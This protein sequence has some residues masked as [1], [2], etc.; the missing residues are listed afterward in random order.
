MATKAEWFRYHAERSGPKKPKQ[1]KKSRPEPKPHNL[2]KKDKKALYAFE[3]HAPGTRPS[4]KSSRKA[5]NRQK[6]DA[7]FR[8]TRASK[9]VVPR[10]PAERASARRR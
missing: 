10:P 9:E 5:S 8:M 4:R 7:K 2:A 6:T 1:E 3:D